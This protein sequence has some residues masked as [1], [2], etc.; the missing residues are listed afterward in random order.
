MVLFGIEG[1]DDY[2]AHWVSR[3]YTIFT[4]A[5]N[6][7]LIQAWHVHPLSSWNTVAWSISDEWLVYLLFPAYLISTLARL[8]WIRSLVLLGIG[9]LLTCAVGYWSLSQLD[10]PGTI[11]RVVPE[12][13]IG[14]VLHKMYADCVASRITPPGSR[15]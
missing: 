11:L 8:S 4:L 1:L 15:A 12:F 7:L 3:E 10:M 9:M 6:A 5:Q 14:V 13:G 2:P